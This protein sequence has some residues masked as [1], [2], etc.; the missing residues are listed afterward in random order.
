[1]ER[2]LSAPGKLFVSGEYAVLWG[3]V[4]RVAAVAPRTAALVR[5]RADGRVHGC[6]GGGTQKGSATPK[7]VRWDGEIPGGFTFVAR[8]LDEALRA[9]GRQSVGFELAVAP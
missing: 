1:M 8:T 9:H 2:A 4:A 7:G 6:L 3:G 5:R